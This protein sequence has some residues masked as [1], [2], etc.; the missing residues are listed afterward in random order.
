MIG[1]PVNIV[2]H[3]VAH[4]EALEALICEKARKLAHVFP[5]LSRCHVAV[6][7]PHR[8][9]GQGRSFNVRL[10]LH[11]PGTEIALNRNGREDAH[12]AVREAFDAARRVLEQHARK[13]RSERKQG[14]EDRAAAETG[15]VK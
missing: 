2:F 11:L 3:G 12:A 6:E 4:S 5:R 15:D 9:D 10:M 8:H 13:L 14:G 7:Q 1:T